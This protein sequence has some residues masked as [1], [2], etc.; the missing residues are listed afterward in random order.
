MEGLIGPELWN[1]CDHIRSIGFDRKDVHALCYIALKYHYSIID[2]TESNTIFDDYGEI[3]YLEKHIQLA[4]EDRGLREYYESALMLYK[5]FEYRT[6]ILDAYRK[7][8]LHD[9]TSV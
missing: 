3:S 5:N 2:P 4:R 8:V 6:R 1:V 7:H 9:N